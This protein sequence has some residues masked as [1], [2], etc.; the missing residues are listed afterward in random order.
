MFCH[1]CGNQA[2]DDAEFCFNCGTKLIVDEEDDLREPAPEIMPSST[3]SQNVQPPIVSVPEAS[4]IT[5]DSTPLKTPTMAAPV[6]VQKPLDSI[7]TQETSTESTKTEIYGLLSANVSQC[8]KIKS[9]SLS[10]KGNIVV[11]KGTVYNYVT[12]IV[13]GQI[14][15]GRGIAVS[16]RIPFAIIVGFMVWV[17]SSI[18]WDMAEGYGF[19]EGYT[20]PLAIGLFAIGLFGVVISLLGKKETAVVLPY[21]R[22]ALEPWDARIPFDAQQKKSNTVTLVGCLALSFVGIVIIGFTLLGGMGS[23]YEPDSYAAYIPPSRSSSAP[24]YGKITLSQTYTN[25]TEGFSFMYPDVWGFIEGG[26]DNIIM[27]SDTSKLYYNAIM[28]IN[29]YKQDDLVTASRT[30]Y[31]QH[32]SQIFDDFTVLEFSDI[33]INSTPVRKVVSSYLDEGDITV[34]IQYIYAIQ[35]DMYVVN[36]SSLQSNFDRFGPVFDAIMDSYRITQ[37]EKNNEVEKYQQNKNADISVIQPPA[38]MPPALLQPAST[39]TDQYDA[40]IYSERLT[41]LISDYNR[42]SL[43]DVAVVDLNTGELYGEMGADYTFV[44]S[45]FYAPIYI[46]TYGSNQTTANRM[47]ENMDNNAGNDL[48]DGFGGLQSI[49]NA[50]ARRGYYQTVF[51]RKFGDT[52]ASG[53]GYENYTSALDAVGILEELYYS[54]GYSKMSWSLSSDGINAPSGV[55]VYAHRGQGIGGA[56]NIFAVLISG[57]VRYGIAILTMHPGE[58]NNQAKTSATPLITEILEQVH[59]LM[60]DIQ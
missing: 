53:Q 17:A 18:G 15:L 28:S 11:A 6:E 29:K 44:A 24:T 26:V 36:L 20:I 41:S 4:H 33:S 45:G 14:K 8:P 21:I 30:E 25:E 43:V 10:K 48:I 38:S 39:P 54:D 22:K 19:D 51:E 32:F 13:N 52:V 57:N 59:E 42:S 47:L 31:Q 16:F 12:N 40:N 34:G 2:P 56:Y 5:D 58:T 60:M 37:K 50:L 49:N 55:N 3:P 7:Q 46:L 23:S 27:I 1:V 35:E 9:V